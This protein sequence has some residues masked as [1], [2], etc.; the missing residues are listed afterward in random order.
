M[1]VLKQWFYRSLAVIVALVGIAFVQKSQPVEASITVSGSTYTVTSGSDLFN[2]LGNTG[3]YWSSSNVPP[4]TMTI[5]IANSITLPATSPILYSGLNNATIAIDFQKYQFYAA[6]PTESRIIISNTSKAQFTLSN[7]NNVSSST[8]NLV[9]NV[10]NVN[11]SGT[12]TAY[13][14]T[15]YGMLLSADYGASLATTNCGASITYNNVNYN[16]PNDVYYNQPITTYYVPINFTGTNTI[17]AGNTGQQLGEMSNI[18][19]IN[20]TTTLAGGKGSGAF[21]GAMIYPYYNNTSSK[22][23]NVTV[24][25]SATLN[26][27][28]NST[29]PTFDFIGTNNSLVFNNSGTLNVR[30]TISGSLIAGAGTN[31]TTIN[32][33]DGS[34]TNMS[35]IG[36]TFNNTMASKVFIMNLAANTQTSLVSQS[37]APLW[38]SAA[39]ASGSGINVTS[40]A[41]LLT[42]SGG[43]RAGGLTNTT[44]STI[45]VNFVSGNTISKGYTVSST[46]TDANSYDNLTPNNTKTNAGG[47]TVLSNALDATTDNGL[48]LMFNPPTLLVTGTNFNWAYSLASLPGADT[49]LSRTSGDDISFKV[50]GTTN[51]TVTADYQPTQSSQP[52][53]M[54]FKKDTTLTALGATPQTILSNSDMTVQSSVYTRTFDKTTGL[55]IKANNRAK[56]G[57]FRGTVD[58]TLVNGVQ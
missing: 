39:W 15:Y 32:A 17:I 52:F 14:N 18:N 40:T 33:T 54:W 45:P 19:V 47:T 11:G 48:L 6:S 12:M 55:L 35:T 34:I 7:V 43:F 13:Y 28:N 10:P 4:S 58:W 36:P 53:S 41:K 22:I 16:M 3:N 2:L 1:A 56:A 8:S 42:Y 30:S 27:I 25:K 50:T 37:S 20:G 46:P 26:L 21:L 29:S 31:G 24:A 51:F 57:T 44:T 49:L 5:K 38:N 9:S 23:F